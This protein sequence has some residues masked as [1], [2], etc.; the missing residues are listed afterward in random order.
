M[1]LPLPLHDKVPGA[2]FL[3]DV[4]VSVVHMNLSLPSNVDCTSKQIVNVL[5][6]KF[7]FES[8]WIRCSTFRSLNFKLKGC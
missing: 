1:P 6:E 7:L 8:L 2:V 4:D 3:E 5:A